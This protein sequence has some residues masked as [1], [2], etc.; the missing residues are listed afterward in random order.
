MIV[1]K[2]AIIG[3]SPAIWEILYAAPDTAPAR[4]GPPA[5]CSQ[6]AAR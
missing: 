3:H 2:P 6:R 1:T 4:P 5:P